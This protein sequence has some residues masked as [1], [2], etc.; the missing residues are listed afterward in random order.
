MIPRDSR[1]TRHPSCLTNGVHLTDQLRSLTNLVIRYN[2]CSDSIADASHGSR[3]GRA[4]IGDAILWLGSAS[5][6]I[7]DASAAH[8]SASSSIADATASQ[9]F[10]EASSANATGHLEQGSVSTHDAISLQD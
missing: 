8:G 10:I 3:L 2:L 7:G 4:S 5:S 9:K 6:S 1:L